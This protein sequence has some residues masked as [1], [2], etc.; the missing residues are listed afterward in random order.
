MGYVNPQ[1]TLENMFGALI[2][3]LSM[4]SL[5]SVDVKLQLFTPLTVDIHGFN[6]ISVLPPTLLLV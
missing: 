1:G 6:E 3:T 2:A 5:Q 4:S